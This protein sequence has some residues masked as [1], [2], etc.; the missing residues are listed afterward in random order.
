MR[1]RTV[2]SNTDAALEGPLEGV[3]TV[4]GSP[5]R[6]CT[7]GVD[8]DAVWP[9]WLSTSHS[10]SQG[11]VTYP[12]DQGREQL[13]PR[14]RRLRE[15]S[16]GHFSEKTVPERQR[17][18]TLI[19]V[20]EYLSPIPWNKTDQCTDYVFIGLFTYTETSS[21]PITFVKKSLT[22]PRSSSA[23]LTAARQDFCGAQLA[24]VEAERPL[25]LPKRWLLWLGSRPLRCRSGRRAKARPP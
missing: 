24:A 21:E 4:G 14:F 9:A 23:A 3:T 15:R 17:N 20:F 6:A 13:L 5:S 16:A 19:C 7:C 1:R 11:V 10:T 2:G 12:L 8:R 22:R 25:F 18:F